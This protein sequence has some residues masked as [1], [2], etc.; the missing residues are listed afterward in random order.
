MLYRSYSQKPDRI[1]RKRKKYGRLFIDGSLVQTTDGVSS[2]EAD[3][4]SNKQLE[5]MKAQQTNPLVK[6]AVWTMTVSMGVMTF[7]VLNSNKYWM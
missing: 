1:L 3:I 5:V 4:S 7:L 6:V 2:T